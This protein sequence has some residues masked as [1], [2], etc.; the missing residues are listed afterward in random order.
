MN[1]QDI[2]I[3]I[4]AAMDA[5]QAANSA[6]DLKKSI[7]ELNALGNELGDTGSAA[8]AR[9]K[10][11]AGQA[12]LK[13]REMNESTRALAGT[14]LTATTKSF[15]LLRENLMTMN[16]DA[17]SKNVT[18]FA[19]SLGKL[20]PEGLTEGFG[21]LGSSLVQLGKTLLTN[22]IF[23]I[24]AAIAFIIMK[25]TE[26]KEAGGI[27]GKIFVAIGQA[28][29]AVI[30]FFTDLSDAI[31]LTDIAGKKRLENQ[32]KGLEVEKA[33]VED[34]YKVEVE[35]ARATHQS[36]SQ[37]EEDKLTA[38]YIIEQKKIALLQARKEKNG[39]LNDE[40]KKNL[41]EYKIESKKILGEI[42]IFYTKLYAD[43]TEGQEKYVQRAKQLYIESI[44]DPTKKAIEQAKFDREQKEKEETEGYNKQ[45]QDLQELINHLTETQKNYTGFLN[46]ENDKELKDAQAKLVQLESLHKTNAKAIIDI[47]KKANDEALKAKAEKEEQ[48][49]K[50]RLA[51][52]KA[53]DDILLAQN[54]ATQDLINNNADLSEAQKFHDQIENINKRADLLKKEFKD[55]VLSKI[56]YDNQIA[57][58]SEDAEKLQADLVERDR[59]RKEDAT[60]KELSAIVKLEQEKVKYALNDRDRLGASI[61]LVKHQADLRIF[62]EK[63]T[64][65]K[66][67]TLN[68]ETELAVQKLNADAELKIVSDKQNELI[69]V[70]QA[71]LTHLNKSK[72]IVLGKQLKDLNDIQNAKQAIIDANRKRELVGVEKGSSDEIKILKKYADE[73]KTLNQQTQDQKVAAIKKAIDVGSGYAKAGLDI[74]QGLADLADQSENQRLKKGEKASL[75]TQ[76]KQFKRNKVLKMT[77]AIMSTA[78]GIAA[79]VAQSPETGGLPGSAIAAAIGG[80]QIA[81]IAS[82]KFQG[83]DDGGS[84]GDTPTAPSF[85]T[86]QTLNT[87]SPQFK[88]GQFYSAGTVQPNSG[89]QATTVIKAYV[90]ESDITKAQNKVAVI[91]QRATLSGR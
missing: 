41:E 3:R 70:E 64:G 1:E 80:L 20:N 50:D 72:G 59:L 42:E 46:A 11:A 30:K 74:A 87:T 6:K 65:E 24:G 25:F 34:R 63:L 82:T 76:K 33:A 14:P 7:R 40:E 31:G 90:V 32:L 23:L 18:L 66:L 38:L 16:F 45:K 68:K 60:K 51:K 44:A 49:E 5:S 75:E 62:N 56:D 39:E 19:S 84:G 37:L 48:A 88:S 12:S 73:E 79:A 43:I 71:E 77:G 78:E 22:P 81:K 9:I 27:I 57:K 91:Q 85:G 15:G 36:V 86:A 61:D 26:L 28:I 17:L 83:E 47:E 29:H 67:I 2:E 55:G 21:K 10:E 35:K 4:Q 69:K 58:L 53:A 52:L 54:K 8:Y 13:V 89:G